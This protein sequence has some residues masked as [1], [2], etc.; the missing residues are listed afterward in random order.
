MKKPY[1][2]PMTEVISMEPSQ[3]VMPSSGIDSQ[4]TIDPWKDGGDTII[5]L[6]KTGHESSWDVWN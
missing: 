5:N 6:A 4:Y 2:A 3:P 1:I